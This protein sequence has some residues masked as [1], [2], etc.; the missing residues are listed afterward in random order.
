MPADLFQ[1]LEFKYLIDEQQAEQIR[2][3]IAPYCVPDRYNGTAGLGYP[4]SSL[5]LDTSS[6][7]F[8]LAKLRND[9]DRVKL[10]ARV[11]DDVGPVHLE[12]KR[13][14]VDVIHKTRATVPRDQ[15]V[16]AAHGFGPRLDGRQ[17]R[18]LE[19]FAHL[20][21]QSGA[22]PQL[23]V[24]YEREAYASTVDQYA[25][26][27]FDRAVR[28][29]IQRGWEFEPDGAWSY[30][31]AGREGRVEGFTLLELKA[32]L[33]MPYWMVELVRTLRLKNTG[34]SKYSSGIIATRNLELGL[35][36]TQRGM[37]A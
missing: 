27:T 34:F 7:A 20:A 25:R 10:R 21:A 29:S 24:Q 2:R 15:W 3:H 6:Y 18:H 5:Y 14:Q 11:Y 12:V 16:D 30:L 28:A 23:L 1:R 4:I 8:H 37:Y 31:D 13:K 17:A 35:S 32:E 26:V 22:Q 9:P 19:A 33:L 36:E